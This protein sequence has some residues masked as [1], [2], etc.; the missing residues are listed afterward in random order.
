LRR[1]CLLQRVIEGMIQGW[2]GFRPVVRQTIEWNVG[3][4]KLPVKCIRRTVFWGMRLPLREA[5]YPRPLSTE[6]ENEFYASAPRCA[7]MTWTT[8]NFCKQCRC[9]RTVLSITFFKYWFLNFLLLHFRKTRRDDSCLVQPEHVD[10][11]DY[12]NKELCIDGLY[13]VAYS[14][15]LFIL[16]VDR[17]DSFC[18]HRGEICDVKQ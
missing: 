7:F 9:C 5:D 1:N 3:S 14:S 16:P 2:R 11:C 18:L 17:M 13:I 6:C 12:Y 15:R 8:F 10:I 4:T